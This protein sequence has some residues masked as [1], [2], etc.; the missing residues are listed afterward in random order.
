MGVKGSEWWLWVSGTGTVKSVVSVVFEHDWSHQPGAGERERE[1]RR[2]WSCPWG[3]CPKP[4]ADVQGTG[5]QWRRHSMPAQWLQ[6]IGTPVPKGWKPH[7]GTRTN[8]DPVSTVKQSGESRY[9][10]PLLWICSFTSWFW[11][12]LA[13]TGH[14]TWAVSALFDINTVG[15]WNNF[16]QTFYH[17]RA[18]CW[19]LPP[20]DLSEVHEACNP[21][22][23]AH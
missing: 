4:C 21:F 3:H 1:E 7:G 19:Y 13:W 15:S 22:L 23:S 9:H 11:D 8:L 10:C 17:L 20:V 16:R 2:V 12:S 14:T 18:D 6:S 5:R